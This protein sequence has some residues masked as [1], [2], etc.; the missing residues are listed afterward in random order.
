[1]KQPALLRWIEAAEARSVWLIAEEDPTRAP[2]GPPPSSA[3]LFNLLLASLRKQLCL[4]DA[5]HRLSRF[6]G[7]RSA[8]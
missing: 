8:D 5:T 4:T 1:M 3:H 6:G 7:V 2:I